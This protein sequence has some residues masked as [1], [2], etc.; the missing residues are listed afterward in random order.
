MTEPMKI[1]YLVSR[2]PSVTETFILRE[3]DELERR[4]FEIE[5]FSLVRENLDFVHESAQARLPFLTAGTD[6]GTFAM[7][8]SQLRWLR[9]RPRRLLEAWAHALWG[10]RRSLKFLSRAVAAVPV[11]ALFAERIEQAGIDRVHAHW[12]THPALAAYVIGLLTDVPYGVTAH[13]HDIYVDQSMLAKKLGSADAVVTIS[14]FN[15]RYLQDRVPELGGRCSVV[16][17][18]IPAATVKA[19]GDRRPIEPHRPVDVVCVAQLKSYK[20]HRHLIEA[21]RRLL[22][23]G[24]DFRCRLAG[25]GPEREPLEQLVDELGLGHHIEFLGSVDGDRVATLLAEADLFVLPSVVDPSG[26]MEGLPVAL[27]EAMAAGV[28]VVASRLSGIPELIED[29]ETGL[30]VE[31]GEPVALAA[32]MKRLIGDPIAALEMARKASSR[33]TDEFTI[34]RN[35]ERLAELFMNA[36][37]IRRTASVEQEK[38]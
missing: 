32:A 33:V 36:Q 19:V 9:R 38:V 29:E 35:G 1:A 11:A 26:K 30:L 21:C 2:F 22:D 6:I 12:A 25:D 24:V 4:G 23:D 13:A 18:G 17:C 16:R 10:N 34:E 27:M 14:E 37:S 8:G 7:L 15:R 3:M 5:L 31:P 28:P 20:G